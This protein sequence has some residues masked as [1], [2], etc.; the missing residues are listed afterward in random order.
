MATCILGMCYTGWTLV[1][2]W[3]GLFIGGNLAFLG[4]R[5]H[6]LGDVINGLI[7]FFT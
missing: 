4:G 1:W 6:A 2:E 3:A 5:I 7:A